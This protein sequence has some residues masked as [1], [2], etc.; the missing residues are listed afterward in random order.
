MP[1]D[2]QLLKQYVETH[3]EEAFSRIVA[4]HVDMVYSA[5]LRQTRDPH[6]A[7]DATQAVFTILSQKAAELQ[8]S[9]VL[10]GWLIKTARFASLS[11]LRL[12]QTIKERERKAGDIMQSQSDNADSARI[13]TDVEPHIDEALGGIDTKYRDAVICKYFNNVTNAQAAAAFDITEDA[14]EKRL[15]RGLEKVKQF[16]MRKGLV[17]SAAALASALVAKTT[18]A[19]PAALTAS[20]TAVAVKSSAV[21]AGAAGLHIVQAVLKG[22]FMAK[23]KTAVTAAVV[24]VA[25]TVAVGTAAH[26]VIEPT[27][28]TEALAVVS[29]PAPETPKPVQEKQPP[30]P[31]Y[32]IPQGPDYP[33]VTAEK[34]PYVIP[35]AEGTELLAIPVALTGLGNFS[36][37]YQPK[38]LVDTYGMGACGLTKEFRE[39]FRVSDE[40]QAKIQEAFWNRFQKMDECAALMTVDRPEAGKIEYK[41]DAATI[42]KIVEIEDRISRELLSDVAGIL[43]ENRGQVVSWL[44]PDAIRL[45]PI[46]G[47]QTAG[48]ES[49]SLAYTHLNN[50]LSRTW[51]VKG[52]MNSQM[53]GGV[54][55]HDLPFP[56]AATELGYTVDEYRSA[57]MTKWQETS[58]GIPAIPKDMPVAGIDKSGVQY[59]LAPMQSSLADTNVIFYRLAGE[60]EPSGRQSFNIRNKVDATPVLNS[61]MVSLLRLSV[62]EQAQVIEILRQMFTE[63]D[64]QLYD[65][66]A[67]VPDQNNRVSVKV[68][69][70]VKPGLIAAVDSA[71]VEFEKKLGKE[72][73]SILAY[74]LKHG[75]S[76]DYTIFPGA[77]DIAWAYTQ[78]VSDNDRETIDFNVLGQGGF[79]VH[80]SILAQKSVRSTMSDE[81]QEV[82]AF[83]GR[84]LPNLFDANPPAT[85][86]HSKQ[87]SDVAF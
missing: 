43:G 25:A 84:L 22:M 85:P 52:A 83:L 53:A 58:A 50:F 67:I 15:S 71:V 74:R 31:A 76:T 65:N 80:M 17:M 81:K 1:D 8:E 35:S 79:Y 78:F 16:L 26:Y 41:F 86:A 51:T 30:A 3:S 32:V 60:K 42:P 56:A 63:M 73:A 70:N 45:D 5:C 55:L 4:S 68:S 27:K 72:R 46:I 38:Y 69:R 23:V 49:V 33:I 37:W 13:W 2:R 14:F 48:V 47:M 87:E 66:A 34:M 75:F 10:A 20:I 29:R 82:P 9:V 59:V 40:E 28:P 12:E 6:M 62:E 11:A 21:T 18:Y 39:F 54:K 61:S 7:E 57:I 77:E 36:V 24:A 44:P 64:K 19:A